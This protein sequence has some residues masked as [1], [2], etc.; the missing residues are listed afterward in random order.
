VLVALAAPVVGFLAARPAIERAVRARVE[1]ETGALGLAATIGSCR[2]TPRLALELRE[3]VVEA[4]GRVR[5]R[6]RSA[7]VSPRLSLLG[8]V[9]RAANVATS[10]VLADL[11]GGVRLDLAPAEW[12]VESR[13][14]DRRIALVGWG[15]T[16]EI[17]LTRDSRARRVEARADGLRLSERLRVLLH[18]C[19]VGRL[20]TIDGTARVERNAA[21][22]VRVATSARARGLALASLDEGCA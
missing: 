21:G 6:A 22:E 13:R 4:P 10:G 1:R 16:L 19:P 5:V 8:V 18:G 14:R 2:L 11:P 20:G 17:T 9:G 15:E 12:V 3:I 7:T